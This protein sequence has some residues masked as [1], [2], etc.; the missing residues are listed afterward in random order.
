VVVGVAIVREPVQLKS[1][2]Q[3]LHLGDVEAALIVV[4]ALKQ[5][6][7]INIPTQ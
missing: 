4:V 1:L 7:V 5:L 3:F 6:H 2:E